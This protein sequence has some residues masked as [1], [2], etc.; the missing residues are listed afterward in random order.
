MLQRVRFLKEKN[1]KF[2]LVIMSATLEPGLIQEYFKKVSIDIPVIRIPGR[3]F[4]VT[5][6]L[7]SDENCID[8]TV[9]SFN[10]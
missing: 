8:E 3:T 6:Y 10:E 2:R 4:P 7:D 9:K 5:K 1:P